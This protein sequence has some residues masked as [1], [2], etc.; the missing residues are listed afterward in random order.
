MQQ[1]KANK[2]PYK[3]LV[4]SKTVFTVTIIVIVLTILSIWLLGLGQHRTI[5]ENSLLSISILST[6]FFLF[7]TIGLFNGIK[8]KDDVGKLTDKLNSSKI[9]N[10]ADSTTGIDFIDVGDGIEGILFSIVLWIVVTILIALFIWLFGAIFWTGIIVFIAMLYWIFFRALRLVFKNSNKCKG[11]LKTS[12]TYGIS[13][14]ILYNFW[15]YC[16][17]LAIHYLVK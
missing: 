8:L 5:F 1:Q 6:A 11:N 13:Y 17:I 10:L 3:K 16:I 2:K 7:L 14:T 15:I 9:P 4:T 12:I